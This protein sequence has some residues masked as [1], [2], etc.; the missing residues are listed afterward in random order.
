MT[1]MKTNHPGWKPEPFSRKKLTPIDVQNFLDE[2]KGRAEHHFQNYGDGVFLHPHEIVGCL[3]GQQLKL[4]AAADA[5]IYTGDLTDFRERCMKTVFAILCG[6]MSV[7]KLIEAKK[8][9]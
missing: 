8:P 9:E 3:F 1:D 7:D 4:S 6:A 2:I 5:S